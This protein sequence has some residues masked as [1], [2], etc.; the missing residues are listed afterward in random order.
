MIQWPSSLYSLFKFL[1]ALT[2]FMLSWV[3]TAWKVSKYGVFSG[4]YFL[5]GVSES[6]RMRENTDQKKLRIWSLF[7]QCELCWAILSY[8]YLSYFYYLFVT[9]MK[10]RLIFYICSFARYQTQT[11]FFTLSKYAVSFFYYI[12]LVSVGFSHCF[13]PNNST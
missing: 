8:F 13:D 1:G 9:T 10:Q 2:I 11:Y 5:V 4:L 7:T 3:D 12:I 6:V